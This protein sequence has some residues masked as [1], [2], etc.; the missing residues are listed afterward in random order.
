MKYKIKIVK[1]ESETFEDTL[2]ITNMLP[3]IM[4]NAMQEKN[5]VPFTNNYAKAALLF[6]D[7]IEKRNDNIDPIG[8]NLLGG[9]TY[10]NGKWTITGLSGHVGSVCFSHQDTLN[11]FDDNGY[12]VDGGIAGT[13]NDQVYFVDVKNKC[14]YTLTNTSYLNDDMI[15]KKFQIKEPKYGL[16]GWTHTE[17]NKT[18]EN[19]CTVIETGTVPGNTFKTCYNTTSDFPGFS[20]S[21]IQN[22][23]FNGHS[24]T[25]NDRYLIGFNFYKYNIFPDG[26]YT[27]GGTNY[28]VPDTVTV[29]TKT[30]AEV[31]IID[32]FHFSYEKY[33]LTN[34]DDDT[35]TT[36]KAGTY[37]SLRDLYDAGDIIQ[38]KVNAA[39]NDNIYVVGKAY[40]ETGTA[41]YKIYTLPISGLS[42]NPSLTLYSDYDAAICHTINR[43]NGYYQCAWDSYGNDILKMGRKDGVNC[44]TNVFQAGMAAIA[45]FNFDITE[46]DTLVITIEY[47]E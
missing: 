34:L 9:G 32:K 10:S 27:G 21:E 23:N 22:G 47:E 37:T 11:H 6:S 36:I 26:S 15:L 5:I 39:D 46:S 28:N 45:N 41:I 25:Q 31:V 3:S 16:N 30:H 19:T 2:H 40:D 7:T 42:S 13:G 14:F 35:T 24:I 8:V 12:L 20:K 29:E 43:R 17:I 4:N 44:F 18:K 38:M 1:N 33:V